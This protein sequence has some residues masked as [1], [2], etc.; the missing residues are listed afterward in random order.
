VNYFR[1][2][3]SDLHESRTKIRGGGRE[4]KKKAVFPP[5][6]RCIAASYPVSSTGQR[7]GDLLSMPW[8]R[9]GE[10]TR[11]GR[12]VA[13][14]SRLY[15]IPCPS[16]LRRRRKKGKKGKKKGPYLNHEDGLRSNTSATS[17][18]CGTKR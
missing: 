7:E 8:K 5:R 11:Q 17:P 10:G 4:K 12:P 3:Q 6:S 14:A 2:F 13:A 1:G 18:D 9:G 16:A 15:L